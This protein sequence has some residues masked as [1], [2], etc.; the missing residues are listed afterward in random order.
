VIVADTSL[1]FALL[2]RNDRHHASAASWYRDEGSPRL[3][4]T[5]LILAEV[6]HLAEA[7]LGPAASNAFRREVIS[8][9]CEVRWWAGAGVEAAELATRYSDLRLGLA[10]ASLACL[11]AHLETVRIATF[12]ERHFRAVQPLRGGDAFVLLPTDAS[13]GR[14][15]RPGE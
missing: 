4:C 3:L 13:G 7:R 8:G 15:A 2:D 9:S 12:D 14:G 5:P 11:A 1:L 10:D 6:D